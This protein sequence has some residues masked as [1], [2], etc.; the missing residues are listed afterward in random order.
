MIASLSAVD[1][2]AARPDRAGDARRAALE[3]LTE[4]KPDFPRQ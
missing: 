1:P 2:H 4:T 3:I